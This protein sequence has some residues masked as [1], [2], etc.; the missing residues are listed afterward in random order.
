[1]KVPESVRYDPDLDVFYVANIDGNPSQ[2]DGK[3]FIAIIPAESLSV[4]RTLA[5][6][7]RAGVTLNAPKGMALVGDTL[8]VADI[9]VV[10]GFN[11]RTGAVV[12]TVDLAPLGATFLNDVA[13]GPQGAVYITDT[14]IRFEADGSMTQPGPSRIFR[15]SQR[16]ATE[17]ARSDSLRNA[18]GITWQDTTGVWLL[19]PFG[20]PDIQTWTEGDSLPRRL[21]TGPGQYDGIEALRDGRILV[22]S[23][24]DS[25]VYLITHG[26]MTKLVSGVS[27]PADIGYDLKRG[28]LAIPRFNDGKVDFY[29][30]KAGS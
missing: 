17:V 26:T 24:A 23:W 4:V 28:V 29:Q 7:G 10:R 22:S 8:W 9:D 18:N 13:T 12:A 21:A 1:M 20:A 30:L 15:L 19:A 5:E 14:G 11:R 16:A 27:A 3:A 25:S 2:K 6:G